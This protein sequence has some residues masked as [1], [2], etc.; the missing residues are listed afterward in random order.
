MPDWPKTSA[1]MAGKAEVWISG[2]KAGQIYSWFA[3]ELAFGTFLEMQ[4]IPPP[5]AATGSIFICSITRP[6]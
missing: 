3:R 2:S 1:L 5:P 6:G 4:W